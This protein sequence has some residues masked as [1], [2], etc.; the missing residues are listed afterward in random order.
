M[1]AIWD[2]AF[3]AELAAE[4]EHD[5][6]PANS[7]V[8]APLRQ[9]LAAEFVLNLLAGVNAQVKSVT[10]LDLWPIQS[11]TSYKL[12]S[13]AEPVSRFD[14]RFHDRY[15]SVGLFP[16]VDD[17]MDMILVQLTRALTGVFRAQI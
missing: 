11:S 6:A 14:D 13:G 16:G 2:R 17:A 9:P 4:I 7:W 8:V 15:E 1:I 5:C 12:K 3:A 10:T